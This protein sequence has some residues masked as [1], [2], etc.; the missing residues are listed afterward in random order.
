MENEPHLALFVED[1]D[2]LIF[3]RKILELAQNG[4]QDQGKVY[5]EINQYL[6]EE[7]K[8]LATELGFQSE[9]FKDLNGNYRMMECWKS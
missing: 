9:V 4:L 5:F 8:L 1:H 6:P 2:P 3:Y 7:M